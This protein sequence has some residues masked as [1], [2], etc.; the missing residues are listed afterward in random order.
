MVRLIQMRLR[1][2]QL[3]AAS[4]ALFLSSPTY[5]AKRPLESVPAPPPG[6][7]VTLADSALPLNGPWRFSPGD[8]PWTTNLASGVPIWTRAAF[9]D[10]SWATVDL[11]PAPDSTGGPTNSP[12]WIPGW[13]RRGYP[14]L[15]GFA[16]YRL[17][18]HITDPNRALWLKMPANFEDAYEIYANGQLVGSFGS[19]TATDL[20]PYYPQPASFPLPP[21]PPDGQLE[22]AL[23]VYMT[24]STP[25]RVPDAGGLHDPPVI[26]I[27]S[28]IQLLQHAEKVSSLHARFGDFFLAL[29]T[30]LVVPLALWALVGNPQERTWLFLALALVVQAVAILVGAAAHLTTAISAASGDL[31]GEVI[32]LPAGLLLWVLFWWSWFQLGRTRWI[33]IASCVAGVAQVLAR[34]AALSP[35]LGLNLVAPAHLQLFRVLSLLAVTAQAALLIVILNEGFRRRESEGLYATLPVLLLI[36]ANYTRYLFLWFSVPT[37]FHAFSL[38]FSAVDLELTLMIA[39]IAPLAA[40]RF[41]DDRLR[42]R[43]AHQL[44]EQEFELARQ[45]QQRVLVPEELHSTHFDVETEYRSAQTIG[46]DFFVSLVGRDGSLCVVIGDVS[47]KGVGASMLVAVLVGAARTRAAQDFDPITMLQTLDERLSGR[48]GGSFA[49]CLAAQLFPNGVLRIANAGHIPPYLNGCELDLDGS[50]P[51]GIAGKLNP[52]KKQFQLRQGDI[53]TFMTDGIIEATNKEGELLGFEQARVLSQKH[54]AAIV[55]EA[56]SFGQE[57]DITAIRVSIVRTEAIGPSAPIAARQAVHA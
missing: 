32:L 35:S 43:Q 19:F 6:L 26:G 44:L 10:S 22:L 13:T 54:P 36:I 20:V 46:G 41:M 28:T 56:Q 4:L 45:L 40:R 18:L 2:P 31:W 50:L 9:D 14:N 30:L 7:S 8:S 15:T 34:I 53:L 12:G 39:V 24:A 42:K 52:A 48:S 38:G 57:D 11:T 21:I 55:S 17:R 27:A 37:F 51:L 33:A 1:Y 25:A 23:R 16:W 3:L 29:L 49:T 47:G 5:G